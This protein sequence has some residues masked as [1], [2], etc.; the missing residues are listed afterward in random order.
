MSYGSHA[1]KS[2]IINGGG[3]NSF[4]RDLPL[5]SDGI[6]S[7]FRDDLIRIGT[8][9]AMPPSSSSAMTGAAAYDGPAD[10]VEAEAAEADCVVVDDDET[11]ETREDDDAEA[12]SGLRTLFSNSRLSLTLR[13]P[14]RT[15]G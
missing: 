11:E 15:K 12:A 8:F 3:K 6:L 9:C 4:G 1:C 2:F 7:L 5:S 13:S 10:A 14:A